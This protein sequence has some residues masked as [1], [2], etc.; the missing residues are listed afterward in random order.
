MAGTE[1]M[2]KSIG[3][4]MRAEGCLERRKLHLGAL[5]QVIYS[6]VPSFTH[7]SNGEVSSLS[8]LY[9][10]ARGLCLQQV[11]Q[12][13][14]RDPGAFSCQPGLGLLNLVLHLR[15]TEQGPP[16]PGRSLVITMQ[17]GFAERN[18]FRN[19]D[20]WKTAMKPHL[21]CH[22]NNY[23]LSSQELRVYRESSPFCAD[24]TC[25]S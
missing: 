19:G 18:D 1:L 3:K 12:C 24:L 25:T 13:E 17:I 16:Q 14:H 15:G 11:R 7:P 10:Q 21:S 2:K 8:L 6:S 22:M 4:V 5:T 20:S 9:R 23:S